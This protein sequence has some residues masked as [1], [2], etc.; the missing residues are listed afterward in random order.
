MGKW[1][2]RLWKKFTCGIVVIMAFTLM[3]AL[4]VNSAVVERYYLHSQSRYLRGVGEQL[5]RYLSGGMSTETAIERLE[6]EEK[7][8][9]VYSERAVDRRPDHTT[10]DMV[11]DTTEGILD[12][13]AISNEL[14]DKFR[15]KGLGFQTFW[16]W[17]KDYESALEHG[18][19]LRLYRQDKLNYGILAE[20]IPTENGMFAIASIVPDTGEAVGIV[21]YFL[22]ILCTAST[23]LAAVLMY[24]LVRHITNPLKEMEKFSGEI[25]S[26]TCH[27]PLDIHTGDELEAVAESM[28][29][30]S[31]SLEQYQNMLLDKNRQMEELLDNV[32]HDLKTP[33]SLVGMYAAGIRDGLDDGT[34]LDTMIRQNHRMSRLVERLLALS[35]I[36]QKEYPEETVEL[37]RLLAEE[38]ETYDAVLKRR[39]MSGASDLE[40][41][42]SIEPGLTIA[43]NTGLVSTLFSNLL[44]NAVQYASGG[45]IEICLQQNGS[46]CRFTIANQI[47]QE[48]LDTERIWEPFFVGDVSRNQSLAGTGLG[49]AIVKRI[50]DRC[51]YSA[52]CEERDGKIWFTVSF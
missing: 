4:V 44:S 15:Q 22:V 20:Y 27:E 37:D 13:E 52:A 51:G 28:N 43:G 45:V 39:N 17:E 41:H 6:S 9:I 32:A 7:V 24:I 1:M 49:L 11:D 8:L 18:N 25:S 23:L 10:V 5:E 33:I 34:F 26:H 47:R 16:L 31:R 14:R 36:G 19:K 30:M 3:L 2:N 50:T 21:N 29:R 12:S 48:G 38:I 35:R 46:A 42:A 40:I